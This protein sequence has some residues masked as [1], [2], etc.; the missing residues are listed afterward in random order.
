MS[1]GHWWNDT[2][3]GKPEYLEETNLSFCPATNHLSHDMAIEIRT[4]VI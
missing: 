2:D 1:M 4:V 3:R